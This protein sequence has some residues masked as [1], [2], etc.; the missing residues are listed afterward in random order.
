MG[1]V[2][3]IGH[4]LGQSAMILSGQLLDVNESGWH[5]VQVGFL[6][7]PSMQIAL[8][9]PL[10]HNVSAQRENSGTF[11]SSFETG[12][13]QVLYFRAY[14]QIQNQTILGH[15]RKITLEGNPQQS[16]KPIAKALSLLGEDSVPLEGGW[17]QNSW[18]GLYRSFDN[19]WIYHSHHGWL[20]LIA[21]DAQGIWAWSQ[22]RGWTWSA[23]GLYPFLY[24]W[25]L[26]NWVYVF[27][28][29]DGQV[30]YFNYSTNSIETASPIN[31]SGGS[32]G[33]VGPGA[34]QPNSSGLR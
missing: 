24:Q 16:G 2:R 25:N 19:N 28:V 22:E 3:T 34:I 17:F 6:V 10:T 23:K 11:S 33:S 13:H 20:Y 21:D 4:Q 1:Y 5:P 12:S 32:T 8:N 30:H 29:K 26:L 31:A 7:S 15:I 9:D 14:A 27:P 18:F